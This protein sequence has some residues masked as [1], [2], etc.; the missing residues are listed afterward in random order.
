MVSKKEYYE[1]KT[2]II[3]ILAQKIQTTK[4]EHMFCL[5]QKYETILVNLLSI[6][7]ADSFE[8]SRKH[9]HQHYEMTIDILNHFSLS[10]DI[11]NQSLL[12][13]VIP[14]RKLDIASYSVANN[15]KN[16]NYPLVS[17]FI[18]QYNSWHHF[19]KITKFADNPLFKSILYQ[20]YDIAEMLLN[21]YN[22]DDQQEAITLSDLPL[23]R[24]N[25]LFSSGHKRI[26]LSD[27]IPDNA[28][29]TPELIYYSHYILGRKINDNNRKEAQKF[30]QFLS[31]NN[32]IPT[33][34]Q[35]EHILLVLIKSGLYPA[36]EL[37]VNQWDL[38][39]NNS[40]ALLFAF[41]KSRYSSSKLED[42]KTL[43][44]PVNFSSKIIIPYQQKLIELF[45]TN[46]IHA[47]N[48]WISHEILRV[49][50]EES[51]QSMSSS[52]L[53]F[54]N[55]IHDMFDQY[56]CIC[57]EY[58]CNPGDLPDKKKDI[59]H[60]LQEIGKCK[61]TIEKEKEYIHLSFLMN[62]LLD[63]RFD[64]KKPQ[65]IEVNKTNRL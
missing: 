28:L 9:F 6:S 27:I 39:A 16:I 21:K 2:A 44:K 23:D 30:S 41:K 62:E 18:S 15:K 47:G 48:Y 11:F 43:C 25:P 34:K 38:S 42:G 53:K 19:N 60:N 50:N 8:F 49:L 57:S 56:D 51:Y 31:K 64:N 65:E 14:E 32:L 46:N 20:E 37:L 1:E 55:A 12:S 61:M 10:Q 5:F 52:A 26:F 54:Y 4:D 17:E 3:D 22:F 7:D 24:N 33:E 35:K 40:E 13:L 59:L 58:N 45:K 36:K 63:L 29:I